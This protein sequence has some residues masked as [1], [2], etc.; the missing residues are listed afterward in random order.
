[1]R[2]FVTGATGFVGS[3]LAEE[4]VAHGHYV[5][6]LV[7]S[8]EKARALQARLPEVEILIGDMLDPAAMTRGIERADGV[9]HLAFNHDFSRFAENCEADRALISLMGDVLANSNRPLLITS[10]VAM[11][12]SVPGMPATEDGAVLGR[13]HHPRAA[14]EEATRDLAARG[15]RAM[16]MRLPQVHDRT[17]FGLISYLFEIWRREGACLWLGDGQQ[18][19]PAA[20]VRDVAVAYR[21]ALEKGVRGA[22]Y[23]AVDESGLTLRAIAEAAAQ[24]MGLPTQG[25]NLSEADR[26]GWLAHFVA[27]DLPASSELTRQRLGWQP[28]G[29]SILEDLAAIEV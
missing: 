5:M 7:R 1:M 26:F 14:S 22:A 27:S 28:K 20:H 23:H 24:R 6:A 11:A 16:V 21:L 8:A 17:R 15:I 13:E 10:G 19:W 29:P 18:R 9:A 12:N 3:R 4:L 25:L 2:V